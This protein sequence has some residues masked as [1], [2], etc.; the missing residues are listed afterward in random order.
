MQVKA[1]GIDLEAETFGDPADPP[2]LL[3]MG[4][5]FQLVHWPVGFV[6]QLVSQG[7]M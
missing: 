4:L 5:G 6:E 7:F 2:V 1:N 3:I